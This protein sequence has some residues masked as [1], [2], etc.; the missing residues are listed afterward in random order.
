MRVYVASHG[1]DK[2]TLSMYTHSRDVLASLKSVGVDAEPM[3]LYK[4]FHAQHGGFVVP[5]VQR[6]AGEYPA[7]NGGIIHHIDSDAWR[8]VFAVTIHDLAPFVLPGLLRKFQQPAYTMSV[9]RAKRVIVTTGGTKKLIEKVV[10]AS[11]GKVRVVPVPHV[12]TVPWRSAEVF[13]ALWVGA[14]SW[15]KQPG[16]FIEL[17]RRNPKLKFAMRVSRGDMP[18]EEVARLDRSSR[19]LTNLAVFREALGDGDMDTLYRIS[20]SVVSTSTYEGW[21]APIMEGYL[22]G[23]RL[24]LPMREPYEEIYPRY[25]AFWYFPTGAESLDAA[26][27]DALSAGYSEPAPEVKWL[28]SYG[29][30][31]AKLLEAYF[32]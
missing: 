32:A 15:N 29:N 19:G 27:G 26:L 16:A 30:V 13:D 17:A 12:P 1:W 8:G 21:H 4:A 3:H 25:C 24:V 14:T 2:P 7:H 23:C 18:E 31:G 9:R 11:R 28:A 22:R 10:P 6:I 20:K 5:W